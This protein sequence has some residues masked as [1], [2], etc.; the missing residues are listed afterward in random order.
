[1]RQACI[2]FLVVAGFGW[3]GPAR[4][5]EAPLTTLAIV[6]PRPQLGTPVQ[7]RG[8]ALARR[9]AGC[10]I[11]TVDHL[12]REAQTPRMSIRDA[13]NPESTE[14]LIE[15]RDEAAD[16]ALS[17]SFESSRFGGCP[18]LPTTGE[19]ERLLA[20]PNI[21]VAVMRPD[22][23]TERLAVRVVETSRESVSLR[24]LFDE[25]AWSSGMSGSPVLVQGRPIGILQSASGRLARARRLD[26]LPEPV[27]RL[28]A[29][30]AS[31]P[32]Q[33][34]AA[35]PLDFARLP[36]EVRDAVTRARRVDERALQA[37]AQARTMRPR[38]EQA[39][40]IARSN[41]QPNQFRDGYAWWVNEDL[42]QRYEGAVQL[43]ADG[44]TIS[45]RGLGVDE[46]VGGDRTGNRS[47]C[48]WGQTGCRLHAVH[49]FG[50][51]DWNAAEWL[52]FEG[53]SR[54]PALLAKGF[55]QITFRNGI[56][57]TSEFRGQPQF[58]NFGE[59]QTQRYGNEWILEGRTSGQSNVVELGL[60]RSGDRLESYCIWDLRPDEVRARSPRDPSLNYCQ[61]PPAGTARG[62]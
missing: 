32:G 58:I 23:S 12:T 28:L 37:V 1:M 48:D 8:F 35:R 61:P 56:A 57:H 33:A 38:A 3:T 34:S 9:D 53:E 20:S 16:V 22:G 49:E 62:Q 41:P 46:H 42:K 55:G 11:L 59:F 40:A 17:R 14:Q 18:G 31:L 27:S 13:R 5:Q 19:V 47:L 51:N 45:R 24:L 7:A 30:D 29:T 60:Y 21:E 52:R 36:Q 25:Q 39:A 50:V 6:E 2:V 54:D 43:S 26:A 15:D 44:R 10:S 4:A